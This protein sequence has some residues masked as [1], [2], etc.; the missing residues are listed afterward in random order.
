ML[1]FL[2]SLFATAPGAEIEL[3]PATDP[4]GQL[5]VLIGMLAVPV[6]A[7]VS[8]LITARKSP[9]NGPAPTADI[10]RLDVR[11]DYLNMHL[12][13][14]EDRV[15]T[16]EDENRGLR[17][18]IIE[19]IEDRATVRAENKALRD[20]VAGLRDEVHEL[21]GRLRGPGHDG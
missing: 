9:T 13:N 7:V 10:P 5:Y 3:P 20:D 2:W 18:Q 8:A 1:A 16:T 19:L 12:K 17:K 6:C 4:R 15:K 21:R 11:Q 14:L